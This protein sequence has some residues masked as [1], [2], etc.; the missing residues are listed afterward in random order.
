LPVVYDDEFLWMSD[1]A[2]WDWF[3]STTDRDG[4]SEIQLAQAAAAPAPAAGNVDPD[5]AS[6][7]GEATQG[8]GAGLL[9]TSEIQGLQSQV[10][11]EPET[12]DELDA[13]LLRSNHDAATLLRD[14]PGVDVNAHAPQIHET[15]LR[16]RRLGQVPAKG[17]YW[18]PARQD[19][20]TMMSKLDST[21]V[22]NIVVYKGP[23]SALYGPGLA[24]YD[25]QLLRAPRYDVGAEFEAHSTS[26]AQ[27]E[28]NGEQWH[29]R[30]AFWGGDEMWGFRGGYSHRGGSDY[31]TGNGTEL[32]S[33]YKSRQADLALGS[34]L[35]PDSRVDFQYLRLDQTDVEFP[36]QLFDINALVTDGFEG[37]YELYNQSMF[38]AL[39]VDGWYNQTDFYGDNTR[40]GKRRILPLDNVQE[41]PLGPGFQRFTTHFIGFTNVLAHSAGFRAAMSWGDLA[42]DRITAGADLRY[43]GQRIDETNQINFEI[44][45]FDAMGAPLGPPT[46]GQIQSQNPLPRAHSSNPGVFS[47]SQIALSDQWRV[48]SGARADWVEMNADQM[49]AGVPE[50]ISEALGGNFDQSFNLGAGFLSLD[51]LLTDQYTAN[52]GVGFAMRPPTMTEMYAFGPF[53][54]VLPQ[55]IF[56][57][58]FGDPN[59]RPEQM[60]QCDIGIT[61][62]Q[63]YLRSGLHG[64]H[65]WVQDYITLDFLDTGGSAAYAFVNTPLAT[66]V[67]VEA[68]GE[69]DIV[70]TLTAF[71]TMSYVEGEDR[72]RLSSISRQRQ[73][74]A[75]SS[76]NNQRS[77]ALEFNPVS[78]EFEPVGPTSTVDNE[79][80]AV[81]APLTSRVG[82]RLHSPYENSPWNIDFI[83][84]VVD[85]QDRVATSL[86]ELMTPGYATYDIFGYYRLGGG[87]T[88]TA[89]VRNLTDKFYQTYFDTRQVG[90]VPITTV[91]QPGISFVFG[92]EYTR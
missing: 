83:A 3:R 16:G 20:D 65:A 41:V 8:Q 17:S 90:A 15:S 62:T 44:Q 81:I 59:L 92:W 82:L 10:K 5:A 29:G 14:V 30:Q 91:F 39:I 50:N 76:Q 27:Y 63:D 61:G 51:Y 22:D 36:G 7:G 71:G 37:S 6:G 53:V 47:E 56:T 77:Q 58:V 19:L 40:P 13:D 25:V 79:P 9:G 43:L 48:R 72:S 34:W 75:P 42:G 67:G 84:N 87:S 80:L 70:P 2:G 54:A 55:Y 38:D 85:N 60:I 45:A 32:P 49:V 33:S 28:T 21:M 86:R 52:A 89:G 26:I 74:L 31:E 88:L 4:D 73:I 1:D 18:F 11:A 66:L 12:A 57:S 23:Y 24:F 68:F 35:T 64:Y 46:I 78:G 69:C